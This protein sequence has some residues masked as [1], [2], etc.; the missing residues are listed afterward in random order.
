[1]NS[2]SIGDVAVAGMGATRVRIPM[3]I[4]LVGVAG[5]ES[6]TPSSRTSCAVVTGKT[7]KP[8]TTRLYA[9]ICGYAQL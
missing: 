8:R 3:S 4:K 5:F 7:S 9:I 2:A 1:M 6:A